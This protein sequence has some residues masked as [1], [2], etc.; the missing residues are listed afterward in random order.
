MEPWKSDFQSLNEIST[1]RLQW[2]HG[3]GAVEEDP[4]SR[5]V[6]RAGS[7]S[8]GPRRWSRGRD[9]GR[10]IRGFADRAS[11]GPRRWSRGRVHATFSA[12]CHS[13]QLQW[14]HG[15]GAVEEQPAMRHDTSRTGGFNGATAM[16]PWKRRDRLRRG[17]QP[18][19]ASMGPRR[20]SRGRGE[21]EHTRNAT[22]I[23]FNGA[24]A[25]EPWKST[26]APARSVRDRGL[27]SMG[28]RRWSRGRVAS[29]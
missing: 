16:E 13:D 21:D 12:I 9:D 2:G 22:S 3:D 25:M 18:R 10:T 14:G 23:G 17:P 8:M 24:T 27:A 29:R 20:W 28:P 7:A 6:S 1:F 4:L 15:D 26:T 5:S 11:M 19:V